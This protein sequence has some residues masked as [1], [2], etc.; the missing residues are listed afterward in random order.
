MRAGHR[1]RPRAARPSPATTQASS[2]D[3]GPAR[4]PTQGRAAAPPAS[5]RRGSG[6]RDPRGGDAAGNQEGVPGPNAPAGGRGGR[7]GRPPLPGPWFPLG[8]RF[9]KGAGDIPVISESPPGPEGPPRGP[10]SHRGRGSRGSP[11]PPAPR[12]CTDAGGRRQLL[13]GDRARGGRAGEG[14]SGDWLRA[15]PPPPT[16]RPRPPRPADPSPAWCPRRP[17]ADL[18]PGPWPRNPGLHAPGSLA[19]APCHSPQA[20]FC[21]PRLHSPLSPAVAS[22]IPS[23]SPGLWWPPQ[24]RA[25][26]PGSLG[27][28][29]AGRSDTQPRPTDPGG[30]HHPLYPYSFQ[31]PSPVTALSLLLPKARPP[32]GSLS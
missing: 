18:C 10:A 16:P 11:R 7:G 13:R 26:E 14:D 23:S 25:A 1:V 22:P 17:P 21:P 32:A 5:A 30:A 4:P 28:W 9:P 20:R 6:P 27:R 24:P 3:Q 12:T 29:R 19:P 8:R 2:R 31:A 15:A